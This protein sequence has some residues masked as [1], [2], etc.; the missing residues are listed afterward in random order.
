MPPENDAVLQHSPVTLVS[1]K[2]SPSSSEDA[3]MDEPYCPRLECLERERIITSQA[4]T[5]AE[6][7]AEVERLHLKLMDKK[8]K[9]ALLKMMPLQQPKVPPL[10]LLASRDGSLTSRPQLPLTAR[11][12]P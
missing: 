8:G 2:G 6:L 4:K 12:A 11:H 3:S 7:Q 5:I 1:I 9:I 10:K